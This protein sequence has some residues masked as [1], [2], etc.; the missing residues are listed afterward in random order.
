M[1]ISGKVVVRIKKNVLK[2]L[3]TSGNKLICNLPVTGI[4]LPDPPKG[5]YNPLLKTD[6]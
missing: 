3:K 6:N 1:D 2:V 4:L 5:E